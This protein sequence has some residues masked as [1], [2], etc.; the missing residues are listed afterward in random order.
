MRNCIVVLNLSNFTGSMNHS[1]KRADGTYEKLRVDYSDMLSYLVGD[2][3]LLGAYVISQQDI[4]A[5]N[6]TLE[7]LEANQKFVQR[8]KK[9]GWTPVRVSY[10]SN[11]AN[12]TSVFDTIWQTVLSPFIGTDGAWTINPSTTDVVF[13]NGS[14]AWFDILNAFFETGF[15]VEVAYPKAAVSRLLTANFAFLDMSQFLLHSNSKV[16]ERLSTKDCYGNI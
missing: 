15:Q 3:K 16:L 10:N 2:R 9:F 12:L 8:L 14:S 1:I 6:K 5:T 4:T 7:Q 11:D 13:V